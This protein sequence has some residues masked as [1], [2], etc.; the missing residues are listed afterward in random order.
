[1]ILKSL[2]VGPI[3]SNCFVFGDEESKVGAI[4]D[5]GADAEIIA[6]AV[7]ESG[8]TIQSMIAT[9]GHFDH[10][11]A[12]APLKEILDAEFMIHEADLFF[13][14]HSKQAALNWGFDIAQ[15]PDPDRFLKDN[16]T[17]NIGAL[18]LR[19]LHTPGHSPGGI[20]LH[21]SKEKILF[22]GDTLF[23]LSVGRTDLR[24]GSSTELMES[25]RNRLY[26]LPDDTLVY[27]GHGGTTTIGSEKSS[28]FF[29]Q[30]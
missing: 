27:T 18:E 6:A 1:M 3:E 29:V 24:G 28:N 21:L 7:E 19:V 14:R 8:L 30:A 23:N 5:P 25:I 16:E 26:T 22:S 17:I 13:I 12:V 2:V 15:V 10:V 4:V 11:A 9:H 20:C